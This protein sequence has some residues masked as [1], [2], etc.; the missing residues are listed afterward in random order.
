MAKWSSIDDIAQTRQ[1][2]DKT[3]TKGTI[4]FLLGMAVLSG[5]LFFAGVIRLAMT[6]SD[7]LER[8]PEPIVFVVIGVLGFA[9]FFP[10]FTVLLFA[11]HFRLSVKRLEEQIEE[12]KRAVNNLRQ[13]P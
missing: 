4:Y 13:S 12:I 1:A 3:T 5:V 9:F 2:F 10:W 7:L 11:R 6:R 8:V